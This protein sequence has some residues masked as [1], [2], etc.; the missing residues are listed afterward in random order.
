[1]RTVSMILVVSA[2]FLVPDLCVS[3]LRMVLIESEC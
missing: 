1:M 3:A 2:V